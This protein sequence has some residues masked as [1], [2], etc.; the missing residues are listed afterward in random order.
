V[1]IHLANLRWLIGTRYHYASS[2]HPLATYLD[3]Q[4]LILPSSTIRCSLVC[5]DDEETTCPVCNNNFMKEDVVPNYKLREAIDRYLKDREAREKTLEDDR[6][7]AEEEKRHRDELSDKVRREEQQRRRAEE[8]KA[9]LEAEKQR[10]EEENRRMEAEFA[11]L[12]EQEK[13]RLQEIKEMRRQHEQLQLEREEKRRAEEEERRRLEEDARKRTAQE[14][15]KLMR[16]REEENKR[17]DDEEKRRLEEMERRRIELERKLRMEKDEMDDLRR[18]CMMLE[19]GMPLPPPPG[20]TYSP[21]LTHFRSTQRA[22]RRKNRYG[23][24]GTTSR[25][26]RS[27]YPPP[28]AYLFGNILHF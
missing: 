21:P 14:Q 27:R 25:R 16:E 7:R 1:A 11:R 28:E 15:Q 8:E 20:H 3:Y 17:R 24:C 10:I 13:K 19:E 4:R 5:K 2:G 22:E 9:R 23:R 18:K 12:K 6:R 26:S